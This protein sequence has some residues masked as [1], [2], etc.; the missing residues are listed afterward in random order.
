VRHDAQLDL[1][2]VGGDD[3]VA[4]PGDEGLADLAPLLG[5]DRDVLQVGVLDDSRPVAVTAWW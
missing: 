3:A 1:G 2:V 4:G 5:A